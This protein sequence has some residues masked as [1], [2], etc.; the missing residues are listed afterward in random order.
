MGIFYA[1]ES[2]PGFKREFSLEDKTIQYPFAEHERVP[3]WALFIISF[4]APLCLLPVLNR[5]TVRSNWDWH[6]GTLGFLFG[7]SLTAVVTE[8]TKIT[9]GRPRPDLISRCIPK[10]GS[11]DPLRGLS[12]STICT[13]TDFFTFHDGWRSF[14][15]GHSSLSFAGLGFLSFYLAGKLHLFDRGGYTIKIWLVFTPLV[16]ATLV[17]ISRTMDYRHHWQD[18][19]AG[20]ALGLTLSYLSYRQYYPPL[21]SPDC[22]EPYPPRTQI[23]PVIL[24]IHRG[25]TSNVEMH[26]PSEN[27]YIQAPYHD[28]DDEHRQAQRPTTSR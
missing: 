21:H 26:P 14:P 17:A 4:V 27:G 16:G 7:I 3:D 15:S 2:I 1:L 25:N 9:V 18:V 20:S 19:L 13:Q 5:L 22:H 24:P 10:P 28:D 11:E 12:S 6:T 23:E 8:V